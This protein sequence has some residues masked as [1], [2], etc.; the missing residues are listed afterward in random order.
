[1][2]ASLKKLLKQKPI[3][4]ITVTDIT[5]DCGINRHTFYYHFQDIYE[6]VE[7]F[8]AEELNSV[9]GMH[10]T[11]D[12]WKQGF[13]DL[14]NYL[15]AN[16]S[17]VM[18]VYNSS[19]H[20]YLEKYIGSLVKPYILDILALQSKGMKISHEQ[21]EFIADTYTYGIISI[22]MDW[23]ANDMTMRYEKS[24]DFFTKLLDGS[25]KYTL[26]KF[27]MQSE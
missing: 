12:T 25:M 5:D 8:C 24:I 4:K 23:I 14:Y 2:A 16:K 3:D 26:Q 20:N 17:I 21:L 10:K 18:N 13:M 19:F 15:H 27:S 1:M 9:L 6:L 11:Y 22:S 7:Y